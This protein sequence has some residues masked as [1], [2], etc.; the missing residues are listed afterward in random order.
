[1]RTLPPATTTRLAVA[2]LGAW[3]NALAGAAP[4]IAPGVF[5]EIA[6]VDDQTGRGVPL[7]EVATVNHLRFVTD[8]AGRA[9]FHEPGLMGREVFFSVR[10]HGYEFPKDGFGN[11][12][13]ILTPKAGDRAVLR[14][15]RRNVAERLHRLTG[16]GLYR[17]SV[18]LGHRAPLAE[19]LG[20]AGV[21]G[22]DSAQAAV[23]RG[24]VHW[25]WGD[26]SN[27]K[28]PLGNFRT[29]GAT[30]DLPGQGGLDPALGV[31]LRYFTNADGFCRPMCPLEVN[32]GVVWVDGVV[33]VPD[34]GGRER[35]VAYYTRRKSLTEQL[36]QGLAVWNDEKQ[37]FERA[38]KL[39]L[40]ESWRFLRGHPFR[41]R[42]AGG[43]FIHG[44]EAFPTVR[45]KAELPAVL[46][47]AS[48]EAW[49]CAATNQAGPERGPAGRLR[50]AW[51]RDAA[52]VTP[53]VERRWLREGH[54][55]PDEAR[56]QPVDVESGK[57]VQLHGGSVR[58]NAH[59]QR[60]VLIAVEEGGTSYL[61]EV[62]YA[63]AAE[64][65][66]PWPRARKVVTH[67]KYSFYN[68]VHHD[69]LDQAGGRFIFFEGTYANTFS[70]NP[71]A[72]PRYDYNQVMY[73]LD[74]DDPRLEAVRR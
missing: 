73:R 54:L 62:W 32:E 20:R 52:P 41:R 70:G 25:F 33:T 18:L 29:S 57:P 39:D 7:V 46:D 55:Q 23:Y 64:P 38:T 16:E 21:A 37:L 28:Y 49:T 26:T 10:S 34:A 44:G 65:T 4:A 53:A 30:S 50:Y 56:F 63:E 60:W 11:A 14:L 69:F 19:P 35:L 22:Q 43:E 40:A 3:L 27:V 15:Q 45:V 13:K 72:T 6:V 24:K 48:Y 42:E 12:G 68:P 58:W 51:R 2:A 74:L 67:D 17:D 71:D 61:G 5:F 1:M 31:D 8:N 9:A 47:P 66:G 59:R 36:E